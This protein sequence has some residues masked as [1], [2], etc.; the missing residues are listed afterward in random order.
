MDEKQTLAESPQCS[1]FPSSGRKAEP[2]NLNNHLYKTGCY[3]LLK[4]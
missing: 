1:Y 2:Q 3:F 4:K